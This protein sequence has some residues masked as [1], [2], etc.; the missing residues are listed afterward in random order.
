MPLM[1]V[2]MTNSGLA[3]LT[4]SIAEWLRE[5][6]ARRELVAGLDNM[7]EAE[8]DSIARDLGVSGPE[9]RELARLGSHSADL[10]P[11]RMAAAGLDLHEM[12]RTDPAT[13][14][15]LERVCALC[16]SKGRCAHDL[17]DPLADALPDYCVN[18]D[19]LRALGG[20]ET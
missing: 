12:E 20:H 9:L 5:R 4:G 13:A 14:R 15:D 17:T 18:R 16:E 10:L 2:E 19:T 3:S 7:P 1:E 6:H 11:R 8:L